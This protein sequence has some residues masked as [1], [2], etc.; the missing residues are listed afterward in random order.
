MTQNGLETACTESND[1]LLAMDEISEHDKWELRGS[2]YMIGNGEGKIRMTKDGRPLPQRTWRTMVLSSGERSSTTMSANDKHAGQMIR[3]IDL[4]V[5]RSHGAFDNLQRWDSGAAFADEI[6]RAAERYHGTAGPAFVE[7]F[8]NDPVDCVAWLDQINIGD[9]STG[10]AGRIAKTLKIIAMAGELATKYGVVP[11]EHGEATAAATEALAV[12]LDYH[13]TS[14]EV[15]V[16]VT[17]IEESELI[18]QVESYIRQHEESRFTM[19]V[20]GEGS[21]SISVQNHAGWYDK[22]PDGSKIYNLNNF[23]FNE[24]IKGF[25]RKPAIKQLIS[26]NILYPGPDKASS[27][28][29]IYGKPTRVYRI[30]I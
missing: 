6:G 19:R 8:V 5:D 12:W 26:R 28:V 29:K 30:K 25:D 10:Q 22:Q 16:E 1:C 24:A 17:S 14:D 23:G 20:S 15:D 4:W 9:T 3:L 27:V 18:R 7:A 21:L 2:I 11:W 13:D